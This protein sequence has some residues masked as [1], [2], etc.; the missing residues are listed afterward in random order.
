MNA[1]EHRKADTYRWFEKL[2]VVIFPIWILAMVQF[3]FCT[4]IGVIDSARETAM[5]ITSNTIMITL[6]IALLVSFGI[7]Y[8]YAEFFK[9]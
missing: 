3:S 2:P 9:E 5:M 1:E 6:T 8:I 4:F 7:S